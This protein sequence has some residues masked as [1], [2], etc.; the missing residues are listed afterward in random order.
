MS[1]LGCSVVPQ[2]FRGGTFEHALAHMVGRNAHD[3]RLHKPAVKDLAVHFLSVGVV[4]RRQADDHFPDQSTQ[5]PPASGYG[6][7]L[8]EQRYS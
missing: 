8:E 1:H 6:V 7:R 5:A 2:S 4:E 3:L